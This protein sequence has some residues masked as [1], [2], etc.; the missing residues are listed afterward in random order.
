[1]KGRHIECSTDKPHSLCC[2]RHASNRKPD[3]SS[4]WPEADTS[5]GRPWATSGKPTRKGLTRGSS[6]STDVSPGDVAAPPPAFPPSSHPPAK[7]TSNNSEGKHN[8]FTHFPK[9][10]KYAD[11]RKLRERHA[12]EILTIGRT[13]LRLPKDLGACWQQTTRFWRKN[14]NPD[15]ITNMQWL[16]KTWRPNGVK[17][18]HAK[19]NQLRK[20]REVSEHS[21]V[22]KK[23][24]D[25]HFRTIPWNLLKAAK[26]WIGILRDLRRHRSVTNGTAKQA[27]RRVKEGTS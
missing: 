26:S 15:C 2:P 7:P 22:Q 24:Q 17:V 5:C 18:I 3:Q 23:T 19:P 10:A 11:A 27:L 9:D 16:C 8:L 1:M 4:G 12:E 6:M 25:P 21:Y 20:R 13:E 14:K